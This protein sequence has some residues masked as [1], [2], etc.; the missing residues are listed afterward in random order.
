MILLIFKASHKQYVDDTLIVIDACL[1]GEE[2]E[3]VEE[4]LQVCLQFSCQLGE[5]LLSRGWIGPEE[6]SAFASILGCK[7][8]NGPSK[9]L[10]LPLDGN[11]R[12]KYFVLWLWEDVGRSWL[13]GKQSSYHMEEESP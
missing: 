5:N 13:F 7:P 8:S 10:G 11:P 1:A 9:Y 6:N 12:L 3:N 4:V 2:F